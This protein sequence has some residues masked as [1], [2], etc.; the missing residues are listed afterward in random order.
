MALLPGG[1]NDD[2]EHYVDKYYDYWQRLVDEE[3]K[4]RLLAPVW[5]HVSERSTC[6]VLRDVFPVHPDD[7]ERP[8]DYVSLSLYLEAKTFLHGLLLVED[9][10]CMAHCLETRL[11]F[12]DNELVE[13]AQ[14]APVRHK[15]GQLERRPSTRTTGKQGRELLPPPAT[16]RCCCAEPW[17]VTCPR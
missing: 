16:A 2:F 10:L 14:C 11:P 5:P 12:L 4:S 8:E 9:K 17:A 3:T 6:E 7:I 1:V 13:F 15:V